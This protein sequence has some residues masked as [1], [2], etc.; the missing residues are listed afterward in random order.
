MMIKKLIVAVVMMVLM[1]VA[2]TGQSLNT[3]QVSGAVQDGTGAAVPGAT[4]VLTNTATGFV[5][6]VTSNASGTYTA[7]DL[8]LGP[9]TITVTS[10]GFDKFV[11]KGLVLE[12]GSNPE[13]NVKLNVG[14]ITQEIVVE[15]QAGV[16]VETE[17]NGVG[18]VINQRQVVE[19]PLNG[20]DP[21][22]LIA[23]AGATTVAPAGDLNHQQELPHRDAF[24][25]RWIA[26]RHRVCVG[27]RYL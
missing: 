6:T 10:T 24:G 5:R 3:S 1:T 8:P 12:V 18:T 17:S 9:Y 4:V 21:T 13:I 27:R 14:A 15:A 2:M 7:P 26:E 23:L 25:C 20:R 19:L 16:T 11:E 22:Q